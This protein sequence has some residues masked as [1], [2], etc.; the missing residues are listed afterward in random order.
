MQ[1]ATVKASNTWKE[2][3]CIDRARAVSSIRPMVSATALAAWTLALTF[4]SIVGVIRTTP[5]PWLVRV[6][7]AY[8][9]LFRN[10]PLLVQ[11]FL[12]YHV[13]PSIF[14]VLRGVPSIV[15]SGGGRPNDNTR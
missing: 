10:V 12:W 9:E 7:N 2:N 4:G 13:I 11:I 14:L 5:H 6:G 3:S 8:V 15:P 1:V